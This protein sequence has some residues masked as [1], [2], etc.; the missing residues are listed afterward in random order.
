MIGKECL[1]AGFSAMETS[2]DEP[3]ETKDAESEYP[4]RRTIKCRV[5]TWIERDIAK[6]LYTPSEKRACNS[7]SDCTNIEIFQHY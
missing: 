6:G 7:H 1:R 4:A 2:S 5:S 3:G